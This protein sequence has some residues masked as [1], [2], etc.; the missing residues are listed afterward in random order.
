MGY[1]GQEKLLSNGV[2]ESQ[3]TFVLKNT[4]AVLLA[5]PLTVGVFSSTSPTEGNILLG[6]TS[7]YNFRKIA[8][9][10]R[11]KWIENCYWEQF[12]SL[13]LCLTLYISQH[14]AC[15]EFCGRFAQREEAPTLALKIATLF[16]WLNSFF[17]THTTAKSSYARKNY[18]KIWIE[19]FCG[20]YEWRRE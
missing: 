9:V 5:R 18:L 19:R 10:L 12:F 11:R 13:F 8:A 2:F 17:S 20:D 14:A 3:G 4:W 7:S 15:L 6:S 16:D 1:V